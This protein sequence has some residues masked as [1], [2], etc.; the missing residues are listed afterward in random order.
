MSD[1]NKFISL[2]LKDGEATEE[3][4]ALSRA[5]Q[6]TILKEISRIYI[7]LETAITTQEKKQEDYY[8]YIRRYLEKTNLS[9]GEKEDL[10]DI[11]KK[12]S[13]LEDAIKINVKKKSELQYKIVL[14]Q[15]L[16][17]G[18]KSY[19]KRQ[20]FQNIRD[21]ANSK[22]IKLGQIERD[23]GCQPGYMSRLEKTDNLTD[24]TVEFIVTAAKELD[25]PID[26]LLF[27]KFAKLSSTEQ[28]IMKFINQLTKDTI[29][30]EQFW[31]KDNIK[32]FVTNIYQ[33]KLKQAPF[34][35]TFHCEF[36]PYDETYSFSYRS[37]FL[38][39]KDITPIENCYYGNL[40]GSD[41][42]IYIIHCEGKTG[43][44]TK[45]FFEVYLTRRNN[46]NP[47][48]CTEQTCDELYTAIAMLYKEIEI[49]ATHVHINEEAKDIIDLY[50]NPPV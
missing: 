41:D 48:F 20:L 5:E 2:Y 36:D 9:E 22:N 40:K 39:G 44:S 33:N 27:G 50:F 18:E 38:P 37:A 49:A 24:P 21:L 34:H 1:F 10:D 35:P 15:K 13:K 4:N 23:A 28:Y 42:K 26:L 17:G 47:I 31:V 46:V 12:S 43:N 29:N 11:R 14:L 25:V 19:D 3:F 16:V 32:E 7:D 30:D 6:L 45:K 8:T